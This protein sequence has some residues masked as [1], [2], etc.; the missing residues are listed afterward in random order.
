[1]CRGMKENSAL[2]NAMSLACARRHRNVFCHHHNRRPAGRIRLHCHPLVASHRSFITVT[3]H[4]FRLISSLTLQQQQR[5]QRRQWW[6]FRTQSNSPMTSIQTDNGQLFDK[7]EN[8]A[9]NGNNNIN[10]LLFQLL[11]FI[12]HSLGLTSVY[13]YNISK[14]SMKGSDR[15]QQQ[16]RRRRQRQIMQL[17]SNDTAMFC[18]TTVLRMH[19][20]HS[21]V[22]STVTCSDVSMSEGNG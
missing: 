18:T 16:R 7:Q 10:G 17:I 2:N 8:S 22:S 1:M 21:T 12:K 19:A 5:Q 11:L 20:V 6:S 9:S 3:N 4:R 14:T 15:K 13:I